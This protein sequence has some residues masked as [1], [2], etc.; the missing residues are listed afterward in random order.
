M[1]C[2]ND[3]IKYSHRNNCFHFS[4]STTSSSVLSLS[5]SLSLSLLLARYLAQTSENDSFT[6]LYPLNNDRTYTNNSFVSI[7]VDDL[8]SGEYSIPIYA[9]NDLGT[10][11]VKDYPIPY[12][13]T[14]SKYY[15]LLFYKL[16][17]KGEMAIY[18]FIIHFRPNLCSQEI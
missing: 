14:S 11:L 6:I 15:F 7:S 12:S 3:G 9:S 13:P 5:L 18:T 17:A 16:R 1:Y 2:I 10:V 4:L 8:Q